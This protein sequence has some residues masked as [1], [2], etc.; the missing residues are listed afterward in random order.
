MKLTTKFDSDVA[1]MHLAKDERGYVDVAVH[2]ADGEEIFH[3]SLG[4]WQ[5]LSRVLGEFTQAADRF[6]ELEVP[7]L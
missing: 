7:K 1:T 6:S 4:A 2:L 3:G 5:K